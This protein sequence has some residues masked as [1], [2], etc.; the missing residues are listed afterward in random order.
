[1]DD[2]STLLA[3]GAATPTRGPDIDALLRRARR[4]SRAT[5]LIATALVVAVIAPVAY[6]LAGPKPAQKIRVTTTTPLSAPS[7]FRDAT[8]HF[9]IQVPAGWFRT[10]QPLEPWL[11]S[12]HEILSVAT[13]PLSPLGNHA[14]CPSEIPKVAVDAIGPNGAYLGIYEWIRGEGI[15]TAEPRPDNA[16][17]LHWEPECPLPNGITAFGATFTDRNRDFTVTMVL[18]VN[19]TDRRSEIYASLDRFRPEPETATTA[20]FATTTTTRP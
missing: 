19:A 18:G 20:P 14:A 15:Y 3:R 17:H 12:P 5:V 6:G 7:E 13:V 16:A 11:L 1:M 4:R 10:E 8:H 2:I 9:V